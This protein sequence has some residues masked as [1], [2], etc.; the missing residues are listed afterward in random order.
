[1]T[2]AFQPLKASYTCELIFD[3]IYLN[4]S[5]TK[6]III[7][8]QSYDDR[9]RGRKRKQS[10]KTIHLLHMSRSVYFARIKSNRT[11]QTYLPRSRIQ[12]NQEFKQH[13]YKRFI[14]YPFLC[15]ITQAPLR[16][17]LTIFSFGITLRVSVKPGTLPEYP[18]TPRNTPGTPQNIPGIPPEHP[19]TTPKHPWNIP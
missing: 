3:Q 17:I 19:G 1:M 5:L 11:N 9:H 6:K 7:L 16:R 13:F 12:Y 10:C 18:G 14:K 4:L 2:P 15:C 8:I